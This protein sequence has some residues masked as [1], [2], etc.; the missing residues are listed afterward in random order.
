[1]TCECCGCN[2][3]IESKEFLCTECWKHCRHHRGTY[4]WVTAIQFALWKERAALDLGLVKRED[5]V[6]FMEA[7][8]TQGESKGALPWHK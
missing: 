6:N 4:A 3:G 8:L 2:A 5:V 7:M 1:M